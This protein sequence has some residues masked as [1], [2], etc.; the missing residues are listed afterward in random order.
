MIIPL[1]AKYEHFQVQDD[2]IPLFSEPIRT[3][4]KKL[5]RSEKGFGIIRC[6][7]T[8]EAVKLKNQ[9]SGLDKNI[10][11]TIVIGCKKVQTTLFKRIKY[12]T[13]KKLRVEKK[14][15]IL[16]VIHALSAGKDPKQL[17]NEVRFV[18]ETRKS[19][20]ANCVQGLPGRVCG[21]HENQRY[22]NFCK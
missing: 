19:Q 8:A 17:K 10:Y 21:Y 20:F 13:K 6:S 18:I 1:E 12:F 3:C 5:N 7:T 9:L 4:I 14:K 16:I 2:K 15:V 22:S 11:E